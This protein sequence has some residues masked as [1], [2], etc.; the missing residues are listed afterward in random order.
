[1]FNEFFTAIRVAW[2]VGQIRAR[3]VMERPYAR[4]FHHP[5][6]QSLFDTL[7]S[8]KSGVFVHWGVYGS[9]KT[10]AVRQAAWRLQEEAGRQV[11][12]MQSFGFRFWKKPMHQLLLL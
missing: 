7:N 8:S 4:A 10:T 6:E 5:L 2:V 9:G 3:H 1:M 12:I 11:I